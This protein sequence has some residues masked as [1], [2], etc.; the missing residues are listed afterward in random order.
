MSY[1]KYFPKACVVILNW[2]GRD[3]TIEC[4][5]SVN[6]I[7]YPNY[8]II[9]VDN[10]SK[11][12]SID[13]IKNIYKDIFIINNE[14]NLGFAEGNNVGIRFALN[15]DAKYI[16]LL[17][18]DTIVHPDALAAMVDVGERIPECGILGSK[19]YYYDKPDLIWFA[20]A[21]INWKRAVSYHTGIYQKDHPQY[22][23]LK[24][25][26]RI[27]GCS[28]VVKSELCEKIGLMDEKLFL[29]VEEVDW[30]VRA[31][32]AGYKIFYVPDSKVYH[33]ISSSTGEDF[34]I[35]YNYFHT[36]NFLYVIRKNM[37]FPLREFYLLNAIFHKLNECKGILKEVIRP[38]FWKK[39]NKTTIK[40]SKLRGVFDFVT[41]RMGKGYF[42]EIL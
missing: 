3:D 13:S 29:Y 31:K 14:K 10:G 22:G 27:T 33:K 12:N 23:V 4:I 36:R 15:K 39:G 11:D 35:I 30:C 9:L 7:S 32:N 1:L 17:N 2:N 40:Y 19:I 34:G 21:T 26:D 18:N 25:V 20:G 28:M 16:W 38:E 42:D 6:N 37:S 5:K 8:E 24:E 41:G